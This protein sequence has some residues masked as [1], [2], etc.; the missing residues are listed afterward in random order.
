MFPK[1]RSQNYSSI[2]D[3]TEMSATKKYP[4]SNVTSISVIISPGKKK[5]DAF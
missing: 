3:P 2:L 5:S 4:H 1:L